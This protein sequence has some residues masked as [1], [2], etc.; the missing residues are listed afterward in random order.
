MTHARAGGDASTLFRRSARAELR[1]RPPTHARPVVV[2]RFLALLAIS[3]IFA[4]PFYWMVVTSLQ[5]FQEV[6]SI[7]PDLWPSWIFANYVHTWNAAAWPRFY[8]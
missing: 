4:F 2:L 3:V 8:A 1:R 6:Q 7:P 5:T